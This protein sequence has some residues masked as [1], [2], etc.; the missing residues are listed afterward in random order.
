[1]IPRPDV[2]ERVS[3]AAE[4]WT[5]WVGAV[6]LKGYLSKAQ[7]TLLVPRDP[8]HFRLLLDVFLLEKAIY[9]VA[10]ELNNRP[11]WVRIPLAGIAKLLSEG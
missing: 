2:A 3:V 7:G 10:Y 8:T 11:E 5:A 4:L 9:E 6:Y 1:L